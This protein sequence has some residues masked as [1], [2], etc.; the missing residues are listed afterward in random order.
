[1]LNLPAEIID[2]ANSAGATRPSVFLDIWPERGAHAAIDSKTQFLGVSDPMVGADDSMDYLTRIGSAILAGGDPQVSAPPLSN[3]FVNFSP[4]VIG[5]TQYPMSIAVSP[6]G[7]FCA[8]VT[9]STSGS[10]GIWRSGDGGLT[11][12]NTHNSHPNGGGCYKD[13]IWG[14]GKFVCLSA[15]SGVNLP[16][17]LTS[18]D[19]VTWTAIQALALPQLQDLQT[20]GYGNGK[21]IIGRNTGGAGSTAAM[22]DSSNLVNW[23]YTAGVFWGTSSASAGGHITTQYENGIWYSYAAPTYGV[24]S[25]DDGVS[26]VNA[27]FSAGLTSGVRVNSMAYG[28]GKTVQMYYGTALVSSDDGATWTAYATGVGYEQVM[29]TGSQFIGFNRGNY[30]GISPDGVNW[31]NTLLADQNLRFI[32]MTRS[33]SG[34]TCALAYD[35]SVGS[36]TKAYI[37][38]SL[39][40]NTAVVQNTSWQMTVVDHWHWGGFA[41]WLFGSK[42]RHDFWE[43]LEPIADAPKTYTFTAEATTFIDTISIV[44]QSTGSIAAQQGYLRFTDIDG[45]QIGAQQTFSVGAI[46]ALVN[47]SGINS[48]IIRGSVYRLEIGLVVNPSW[49]RLSGAQQAVITHTATLSILGYPAA[50]APWRIPC[51]S[52]GATPLYFALGGLK[53]HQPSGYFSRAIDVGEVPIVAGEL[54]FS[55]RVP[56]LTAMTILVYYTDSAA[57]YAEAATTNWT[58]FGVGVSGME[59]PAHQYWRF[60]IFMA[61]NAPDNDFTPELLSIGVSFRGLPKTFGTR[62]EYASVASQ[63]F[64]FAVPMTLPLVGEPVGVNVKQWVGSASLR[65]LNTATSQL[66]PNFQAS[67]L[68]KYSITLAPEPEVHNLM[69]Y[70]L[71]GRDGRIRFGYEGETTVKI[72]EGIFS[73]MQYSKGSYTLTLVDD[74]DLSKIEVP[75]TKVGA[76][77]VATTTYNIS[78]IVTFDGNGYSALQNGI[79]GV[80]PDSD[81]TKWQDIGTVWLNVVYTTATNG[82]TPWHL[83]DI[84]ADLISNQLNLLSQRIDY[85]SLEAVKLALPNRTGSRIISKPES[86]QGM[87]ADLAFLLESQ[88]AMKDGKVSLIKEPAADALSQYT[89]SGEIIKEGSLSYR[90]GWRDVKNQVLIFSGYDG[91]G[92]GSSAFSEGEAVANAT[93][94]EEFGD[95]YMDVF[96]DKW[97]MPVAEVQA[98]AT[99]YVNKWAD[100]RRVVMCSTSYNPIQVEVGDVVTVDSNQLPQGDAGAFKMMVLAKDVDSIKK[101]IRFTFLEI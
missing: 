67:M 39:P 24:I 74:M 49:S 79:V 57:V 97:N 76:A 86:V 3:E 4:T 58:Y 15:T 96:E 100:G 52:S 17:F 26:W 47:V 54:S 32:G 101:Q 62:L 35:N 18:I 91:V 9:Y 34:I 10:H 16:E 83:A 66:S 42:Y 51:G 92:N 93:S 61:S 46:P 38:A 95:V 64:G 71:R 29:F 44:A 94:I 27:N 59:V 37:A 41:A 99:N 28:N 31:T 6:S 75:N 50:V 68:G 53:G 73:D 8:V 14:N 20:I 63:L 77:Y 80:D 1:M 85:S 36:D 23:T 82:G 2:E 11:W 89:I 12:Q 48:I 90:R 45:N 84:A 69:A 87:L 25:R 40:P 5:N 21:Y 65:A 88:W 7:V 72:F 56:A 33:A 60:E 13:I 55:D 81:G 43:R 30:I 98:L 19:G 22:Y 78:D 70:P